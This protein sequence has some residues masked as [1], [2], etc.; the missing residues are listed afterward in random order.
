MAFALDEHRRWQ[1]TG[2]DAGAGNW[3]MIVLSGP[4]QIAVAAPGQVNGPEYQAELTAIKNAQSR[5]T[6]D[7]RKAIDYWSGGG[8]LRWNEILL[9]LVAR[10]NLPPAPSADGTYPVPDANNPFADPQFPFGNPPYAARAY[11]YVDG[12]A[13][14]GLEG[15][16]VLQVPV[17]PPLAL[18]GRQ[19]RQG[20]GADHRSAGLS[21]RGCG[22]VRRHGRD[23]ETALP[24]GG[25]GDHAQ[26]GRTAAGRAPVRKGHCQRPRRRP[27]AGTGGGRGV[28]CARRLGRHA[29]RRRHACAVAGAGGRGHCARGDSVEEHGHSRAAADAPA[30]RQRQGLDDDAGTTSSRNGRARRRRPP[31]P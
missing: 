28:R 4:T 15:G 23:A 16:V 27:G 8:V 25:A 19:Q 29:D 24:G 13:V 26:G 1:P 10:S 11:S 9:G 30:V 3:Q 18:E 2:T 7:Q 17:Q 21:V 6:T 14:R 5:L 20:P 31:R 22:D 12:R